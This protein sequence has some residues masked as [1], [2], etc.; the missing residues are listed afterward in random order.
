MLFTTL[1][2]WSWLCAALALVPLAPF[3]WIV[4]NDERRMHD[5]LADGT[6]FALLMA[7]GLTL[8]CGVGLLVALFGAG[9]FLRVPAPRPVGRRWEA[10][11][12]A[13]APLTLPAIY[14]AMLVIV[15]RLAAP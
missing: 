4:W 10:L 14:L 11:V 15:E 3:S 1:R 6:G 13:S 12:A 8:A 7:A 9:S 5:R 2:G